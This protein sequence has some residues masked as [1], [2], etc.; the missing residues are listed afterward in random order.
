MK[1]R[2]MFLE[3]RYD[4]YYGAQK[5]M[6]TLI[7]SLDKTFF[8]F[9]IVTTG[10]GKFIRGVKEYSD[11]KVDVIKIG[12]KANTF[13]GKIL[14]YSTFEKILVAIQILIYNIKILN[15]LVKNK[16]D[17][18]YVNDIRALLYT[19]IASK[20]LK[21]KIVWYIRAEVPNNKLTDIGL[22]YSDFIIT[23]A[24][25]VLKNIPEEKIKKINYKITNIYTGFDFSEFKI[26]DKK[27]A[28]K[29][30]SISENKFVIGY[31]GSI[32]DRKGIDILIDAYLDLLK[33]HDNIEL[34]IAGDVSHGYEEYWNKLKLKI[35]E[36]SGKFTYIPYCQNVSLVY[37]ALD[38]F[39][40]PSRSEGLPRVV[41][42][43]MAHNLVVIC[44]N[45]GGASEIIEHKINGLLI[46]KDSVHDLYNAIDFLITKP[47]ERKKISN[48]TVTIKNKFDL[49]VFQKEINQLFKN[50]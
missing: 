38:V 16:I 41:I 11:Y 20:F 30:L 10:I 3:S 8:D 27:L 2:I 32:N 6:M 4:S 39:V 23:I 14:E 45:V 44:T 47:K 28:K 36:E 5:S 43:A 37:S 7:R 22:K 40:L 29:K 12:K 42:E 33:K 46:K 18:I 13:G 24:N 48:N 21:K 1:R 31:L 49:I 15:Y 19:I 9:K 17:I 50:I 26:L 25:G 35:K 34:V